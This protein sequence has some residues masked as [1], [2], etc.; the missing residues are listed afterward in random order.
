MPSDPDRKAS[1]LALPGGPGLARG[2]GLATTDKAI[3]NKSGDLVVISKD[4]STGLRIDVNNPHP[5]ESPHAH[6][7]EKVDGS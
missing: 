3:R 4:G 5:H 7:E 6:V 1:D 2:L